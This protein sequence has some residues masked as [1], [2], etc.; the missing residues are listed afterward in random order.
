M[1]ATHHSSVL[2][3]NEGRRLARA[4]AMSLLL[5]GL[6]L[7]A[8]ATFLAQRPHHT[9]TL[10]TPLQASFRDPA[11]A[12]PALD[13]PVLLAP[14]MPEVTS[15]AAAAPALPAA[16]PRQPPRRAAATATLGAVTQLASR[17]IAEHMLYPAEAIAR[18]LEG[19]ALV[20]LF[21]D[22]SGN[23]LT[24]RLERSSGHALLDDAAVNAARAVHSLPSGAPSEILLPVRFRLR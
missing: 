24:A 21:L 9:E 14:D 20:M 17:Q 2:A 3:G 23:A 16:P 18:G 4:G 10:P 12:L 8:A 22:E 19:E 13:A 15:A 6:S 7:G 5:H 11:P 1:F